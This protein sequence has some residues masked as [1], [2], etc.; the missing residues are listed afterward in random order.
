LENYFFTLCP[1]H[2]DFPEID[3]YINEGWRFV[4]AISTKYDFVDSLEEKEKKKNMR[5]IQN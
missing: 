1:I 4:A 3:K 2:R 5:K